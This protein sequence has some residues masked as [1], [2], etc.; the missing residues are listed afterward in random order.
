MKKY[1]LFYVVWHEICH[2]L[3]CFHQNE[4]DSVMAPCYQHGYSVKNRFEA[5]RK[6]DKKLLREMY[7]K[8]GR[9]VEVRAVLNSKKVKVMLGKKF[10]NAKPEKDKI[11]FTLKPRFFKARWKQHRKRH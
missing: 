4:A 6:N 1:H 8:P 5:V 11:V 3:G 2:C 7:G 10:N 9:S